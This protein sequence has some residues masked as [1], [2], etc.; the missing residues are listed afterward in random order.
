MAKTLARLINERREQIWHSMFRAHNIRFIN[1]SLNIPGVIVYSYVQLISS[2]SIAC[3][4]LF[5][6]SAA[7][8]PSL[9]LNVNGQQ[10]ALLSRVIMQPGDELGRLPNSLV[11]I[12][13]SSLNNITFTSFTY[14][15]LLGK[16]AIVGNDTKNNLN[17]TGATITSERN[18]ILG[19]VTI[20]T[21]GIRNHR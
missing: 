5:M 17:R 1:K 2:T 8:I 11:I 18:S 20:I 12:H 15:P 13:K 16:V 10:G 21:P 7:M 6:L 19:Y 14:I 4:L 3:L 9:S